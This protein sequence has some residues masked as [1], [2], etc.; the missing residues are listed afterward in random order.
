[1]GR[2]VTLEGE[3]L[4]VRLDGWDAAAA[5]KRELRVPLAAVRSVRVGRFDD[6]GWQIAGTGLPFTEYRAGRF[7]RRGERQFL[8]F[9]RR[10]PVLVVEFDRSAGAP[11]DLVAIQI[12]DPGGVASLL[13]DARRRADR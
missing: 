8:S 4:V 10:E 13:E 11:Y 6:D 7:W 3:D 1:V 9:S 2:R 12:S 5:L